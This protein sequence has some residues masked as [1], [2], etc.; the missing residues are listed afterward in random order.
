MQGA[1]E[2]SA[3]AADSNPVITVDAPM[4]PSKSIPLSSRKAVEESKEQFT[5]AD[6]SE[7]PPTDDDSSAATASE[8]TSSPRPAVSEET[9]AASDPAITSPFSSSGE[10]PPVRL[11]S[12]LASSR[13]P[14]P[15]SSSSSISLPNPT[16]PLSN[17]S[18]PSKPS[19]T[20]SPPSSNP[21]TPR[22][23]SKPSTPTASTTARPHL[24]V[25][26]SAPSTS[27]RPSALPTPLPSPPRA[28]TTEETLGFHGH[29]PSQSPPL[30]LLCSSNHLD[31]ALDLLHS[32]P[33]H[34]RTRLVN[35]YDA[36]HNTP[37]FYTLA[38]THAAL[39]AL[40]LDYGTD[41]NHANSQRNSPLHIACH[42]GHKKAI[43]TLIEAGGNIKGENWEHQQ[44]HQMVRGGG[45]G[46]A[47]M[48][49]VLNAAWEGWQEKV[50]GGGV[51]WAGMDR[52]VRGYYRG[53][54]DTLDRDRVGGLTWGVAE[55]EVRAVL[56]ESEERKERDNPRPVVRLTAAE[57]DKEKAAAAAASAGGAGAGAVDWVLSWFKRMDADH[58]GVIS[59]PEFLTAVVAWRADVDQEAQK[60][61]KGKKK[62]K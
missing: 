34:L 61:Q 4:S 24:T 28:R 11:P 9:A 48:Q 26:P 22:P 6:F 38:P 45:G 33:L 2:E 17:S 7:P 32:T 42:L 50:K 19:I 52:E 41:P 15:S 18:D 46:V 37:L 62:K 31:A 12:P 51:P 25:T 29:P 55:K 36:H 54:F 5:S 44:P 27:R 40:L 14:R 39:L 49:G 20:S 23:P 3:A 59:F 56:R 57:R 30:H 58:N 21:V 35:S 8:P 60:G 53:V 43:L 13:S 47:V 16:P 10:L 1:S